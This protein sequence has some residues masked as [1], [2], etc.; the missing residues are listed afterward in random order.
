MEN[1]SRFKTKK[2]SLQRSNKLIK[3]SWLAC[4]SAPLHTTELSH[5][6]I[7]QDFLQ[8][9]AC[10]CPQLKRRDAANT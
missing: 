7:D 1:S 5:G 4:G 8:S 9:L 3:A 2:G 10:L 6:R